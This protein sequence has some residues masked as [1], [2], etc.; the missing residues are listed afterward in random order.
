MR[1]CGH[2]G[3][4]ACGHAGVR[5]CGRRGL[6]ACGRAGVRACGR[7]GVRACGRA[8]L[9][10]PNDIDSAAAYPRAMIRVVTLIVLD[11][12][13][14]LLGALEPFAVDTPWWQQTSDVGPVVQERYG[15][16]VDVLR[17][18]DTERPQPPGGRV[19]YLAQLRHPAPTPRLK[20]VSSELVSLIDRDEPRR[21]PNA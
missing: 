16:T 13:G 5:A 20:A 12:E 4:R 9:R 10:K 2:A 19:T 7:A 8:G 6:R 1:A 21:A 17:L 15:L 14:E 3:M 18:L 11:V